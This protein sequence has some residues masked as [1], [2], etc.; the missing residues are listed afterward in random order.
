MAITLMCCGGFHFH[1]L[2]FYL[3][4]K[5]FN[6]NT[7]FYKHKFISMIRQVETGLQMSASRS[8]PLVDL[9]Q[10]NESTQF[11][12]YAVI[13]DTFCL[14]DLD[15]RLCAHHVNTVICW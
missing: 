13:Y 11:T 15:V 10:I 9:A 7:K 4:S 3:L 14:I 2:I 12:V 1:A 6:I 5:K 8:I